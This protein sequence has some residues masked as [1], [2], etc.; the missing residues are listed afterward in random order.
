MAE[1]VALPALKAAADA[2]YF[3]EY[4]APVTALASVPLPPIAHSLDEPVETVVPVAYS[5]AEYSLVSTVE[6]VVVAHSLA[7]P[8]EPVLVTLVPPTAH[9]FEEKSDPVT[10]P[11]TLVA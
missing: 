5:L 6:P 9:A 8:L 3:A 7:A 2:W 4:S 10:A 11:S 1:S